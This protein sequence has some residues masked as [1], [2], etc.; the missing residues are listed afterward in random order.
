MM[1]DIENCFGYISTEY[2]FQFLYNVVA[3]IWRTSLARQPLGQSSILNATLITANKLVKAVNSVCGF[4]RMAQVHTHSGRF[5]KLTEALGGTVANN[6][7]FA[8]LWSPIHASKITYNLVLK[9]DTVV[10]FT[11]HSRNRR[12]YPISAESK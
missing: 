10:I 7:P 11:E 1:S 6:K 8:E 12:Y 9:L 5:S 3:V 2:I 4:R